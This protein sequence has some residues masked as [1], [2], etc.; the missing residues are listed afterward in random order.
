MKESQKLLL[1]PQLIKK[2]RKLQDLVASVRSLQ[3]KYRDF[4]SQH[5]K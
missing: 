4:S 2:N 5:F 1:I 3:G